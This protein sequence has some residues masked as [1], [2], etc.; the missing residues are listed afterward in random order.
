MWNPTKNQKFGVVIYNFHHDEILQ[1]LRLDVGETVQIL[2][3]CQGWYRGFSTKNRNVKGI[4]PASFIHLKPF[5][6][7]N[8]GHY[9]SLVK[10]QE[11][12]KDV[13]VRGEGVMVFS[14]LVVRLGPAID[15]W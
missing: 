5:R 11:I 12:Q 2:E 15:L 10:C 1:A 6:I 3:E 7:D 8:E 14:N 13:C 9:D 4:F